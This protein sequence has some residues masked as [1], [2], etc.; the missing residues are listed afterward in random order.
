MDNPVYQEE[1][2]RQVD[3]YEK[4]R[5]LR[6]VPTEAWEVIK[7]T[8]HS[9]VED[10]DKQVRH[11]QPGDPSVI[12]SQAALYAMTQFEEFFLSDI[13]S[14]MDFAVHPTEELRKYMAGYIDSIDVLKAQGA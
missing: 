2:D 4:G 12:A 14:A 9:Y 3:V 7:A 5:I 1:I 6:N 11:I 10:L 8:I 13:N